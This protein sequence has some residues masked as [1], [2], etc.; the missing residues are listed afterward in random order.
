MSTRPHTLA[1][2]VDQRLRTQLRCSGVLRGVRGFSG[3]LRG[4]QVPAHSH[5]T[6]FFLF[7]ARGSG[8]DTR[9]RT[10]S[11]RD[12]VQE[13]HDLRPRWSHDQPCCFLFGV[14][15]TWPLWA[16]DVTP[17]PGCR[18]NGTSDELPGERPPDRVMV[19]VGD[20]C[21]PGQE[22]GRKEGLNLGWY[23]SNATN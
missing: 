15:G 13:S 12:A 1:T 17:R 14:V 22:A 3:V 21:S 5:P 11:S 6:L 7:Q 19:T 9:R 8:G 4:A 10:V 18:G 23:P 16:N 20:A 2:P